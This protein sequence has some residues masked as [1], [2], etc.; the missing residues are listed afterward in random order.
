MALTSEIRDQRCVTPRLRGA[1]GGSGAAWKTSVTCPVVL[2]R[3]K[4]S[5]ATSAFTVVPSR[6]GPASAG[7]VCEGASEEPSEGQRTGGKVTARVACEPVSRRTATRKSC[8]PRARYVHIFLVVK[9]RRR[10]AAL[11][12]PAAAAPVS[13]LW[14]VAT[15]DLCVGTLWTPRRR[16][17]KPPVGVRF[18][19]PPPGF[20]RCLRGAPVA[21]LRMVPRPAGGAG[22]DSPAALG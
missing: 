6:T 2:S 13:I 22:K 12:F 5:F 10:V 11:L 21:F 17:R 4:I 15:C 1:C 14:P 18:P 16:G 3:R 7:S 20:G 8:A 9:R 19:P